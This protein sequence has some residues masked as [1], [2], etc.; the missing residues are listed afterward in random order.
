MNAANPASN[1]ANH[2]TLPNIE[3]YLSRRRIQI[4]K[5]LRSDPSI[6]VDPYFRITNRCICR[7][8]QDYRRIDT[9]QAWTES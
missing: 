7:L 5:L 4:A 9:V 8:Y 6:K 2:T 3:Q 1:A